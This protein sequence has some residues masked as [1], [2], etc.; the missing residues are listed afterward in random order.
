MY[1]PIFHTE[2]LE[3]LLDV[4]PRWKYDTAGP[5]IQKRII[6]ESKIINLCALFNSFLIVITVIAFIVPSPDDVDIFF[7]IYLGYQFSETTGIM[8]SIIYRCSVIGAIFVQPLAA[9]QMITA[10]FLGKFQNYMYG[11]FIE[12]IAS[13]KKIPD[14]NY[15]YRVKKCLKYCID[16]HIQLNK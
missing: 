7:P 6:E 5:S 11:R 1:Y 16:R 10:C 15:Q 12:E 2:L 8:A 3:Q 13:K 9:Y 4:L 14:K